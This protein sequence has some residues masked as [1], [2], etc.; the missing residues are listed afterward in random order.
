MV[1]ITILASAV[2]WILSSFKQRS[3]VNCFH[4]GF[5]LSG[6][7]AVPVTWWEYQSPVEAV[8]TSISE[9]KGMSISGRCVRSSGSSAGPRMSR[10]RRG[11]RAECLGHR[12]WSTMRFRHVGAAGFSANWPRQL[13]EEETQVGQWPPRALLCWE[14]RGRVSI[15][16]VWGGSEGAACCLPTHPRLVCCCCRARTACPADPSS[17]GRPARGSLLGRVVTCTVVP[18]SSVISWAEHWTVF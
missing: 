2:I 10:L 16:T 7:E 11:W 9:V 18:L 8:I 12:R 13:A 1:S 5:E 4:P 17:A 15:R 3:F 14:W 6:K